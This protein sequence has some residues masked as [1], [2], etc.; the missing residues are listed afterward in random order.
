[1]VQRPTVPAR[2]ASLLVFTLAAGLCTAAPASAA[3]PLDPALPVYRPE[4]PPAKPPPA[5][6]YLRRG[7]IHIS[8]AENTE[9]ILQGFDAL[10]AKTHRGAR[11][12]LDLKGTGTGIAMLTH[13]VTPFA[14]MGRGVTAIE[15]VPYEKIVGEKPLEIRIA[16]TAFASTTLATSLGVYVN[17]ANPLQKLTVA[18]VSRIFTT[19]NPGGDFSTWGQLGET[20]PWSSATIHPVAG[21]EH[22]GF[23]SYLKAAHFGGRPLAPDVQP[24]PNTGE[25]LKRVAADAQAIGIAATGRRDPGVKMLALAA[26]PG[27][28]FV[29][30]EPGSAEADDYPFR[31]FLYVYVR[32][33][34]GKPLDPFVKAYLRL[35]LSREGQE[36]IAAQPQGYLPLTAAEAARELAKLEHAQ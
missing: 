29:T 24:A 34:P 2:S 35:V 31:R 15:L 30:G 13:G 26:G 5:A 14:P 8:G 1:M 23:G 18:D 7:A 12:V 11:F 36:I 22:A 21:S 19:G 6:D 32:K 10:Y 27:A 25:V 20:G 9:V 3:P 17:A 28:P 16:H 4:S 33:Q